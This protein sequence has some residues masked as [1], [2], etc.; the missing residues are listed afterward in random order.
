MI[1]TSCT[2]N[3][4]FFRLPRP[5]SVTD[6]NLYDDGSTIIVTRPY[7]WSDSSARE[8]SKYPA[9]SPFD[10]TYVIDD[11]PFSELDY[12]VQYRKGNRMEKKSY[13]IKINFPK[14]FWKYSTSPDISFSFDGK[15]VWVSYRYR[16]SSEEVNGV[17]IEKSVL[18]DGTV[19]NPEDYILYNLFH[20]EI[21]VEEYI[22]LPDEIKTFTQDERGKLHSIINPIYSEEYLK[23]RYDNP[24]IGKEIRDL[25]SERVKKEYPIR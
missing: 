16:V 20:P 21:T 1:A 5:A 8:V 7:Y 13:R 22:K 24:Y 18:E 12:E 10:G 2:S 23:A 4:D 19:F 15:K 25:A 3:F 11:F 9:F 14:D 6:F 17:G